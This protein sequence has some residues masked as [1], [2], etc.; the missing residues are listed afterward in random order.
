MNNLVWNTTYH[1]TMP[2]Q[3]VLHAQQTQNEKQPHTRTWIFRPIL[4][5]IHKSLLFRFAVLREILIVVAYHLLEEFGRAGK[6]NRR[7]GRRIRDALRAEQIVF[8]GRGHQ[9]GVRRHG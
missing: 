4:V 3:Y 7:W 1:Q 9:E 2:D 5:G 8:V 6:E